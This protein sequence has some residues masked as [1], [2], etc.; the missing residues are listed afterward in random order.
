MSTYTG[1][2]TTMDKVMY[3]GLGLLFVAFLISVPFIVADKQKRLDQ[4]WR[5]KGCQMY[6]MDRV[7]NIPAKCN[8]DFTDHYNPQPTREQP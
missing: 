2:T 5:D 8:N 7:V 1:K 6:D 4:E 3:V